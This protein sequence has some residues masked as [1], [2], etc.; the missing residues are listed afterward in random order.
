VTWWEWTLIGIGGGALLGGAVAVVLV[1][2]TLWEFT[3]GWL[4]R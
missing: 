1:L 2:A 4:H 3:R